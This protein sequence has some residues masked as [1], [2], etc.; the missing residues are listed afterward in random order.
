M[1]STTISGN[2]AQSGT[3][4]A[5][6]MH[7]QGSNCFD[8][9]ASSALTGTVTGNNVSLTL[10]SVDGQ[11]TTLSGSV[12]TNSLTGTYAI[13]G[14]CADGDQGNVNAMQVPSMTGSLSG[15]L[16]S[17]TGVV[18]MDFQLTQY[19]ASSDG[20]FGITGNGGFTGACFKSGTLVAG[21]FPT[22]SFILG[23][24]L[25]LQI[26]TDNGIFSFAGTADL[27]GLVTGT[28]TVVGG[29]CDQSGTASLVAS[30]W[31]Y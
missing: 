25:T 19:G 23:T 24:S 11:V 16:T 10:T 4:L 14:G 8:P 7:V 27:S 13:V 17:A 15:T 22:G 28:Y 20:S 2:I 26:Q 3:S 5:G 1:P 12:A 21:S 18:N 29:S 31:D 6:A 9:T 30:P